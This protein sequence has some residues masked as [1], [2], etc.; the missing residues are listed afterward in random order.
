MADETEQPDWE[1]KEQAAQRL[2]MSPRSLE[3]LITNNELQTTMV[4]QVGARSFRAI[5]RASTDALIAIRQHQQITQHPNLPIA[6]AM[7]GLAALVERQQDAN[8][9]ALPVPLER[10]I[11]LT[12]REASA[13][14][15]LS[16]AYLRRLMDS[17]KL[18]WIR[19]GQQPKIRRADLEKL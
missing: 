13:F 1:T 15:G 19:D 9:G 17:K 16:M 7:T 2:G 6:N 4:K 3:R 5:L 11:Y 12:I 18:K 8:S 14:S 10:K